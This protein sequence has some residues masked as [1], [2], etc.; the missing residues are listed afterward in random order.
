MFP[1]T[2][3]GNLP[4][5]NPNPVLENYSNN[6]NFGDE[7]KIDLIEKNFREIIEVLGPDMKNDSL[8]DSPYRVAK[9]FVKEI[10][11]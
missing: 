10:F 7:T 3:L 9:M 4:G 2:G 11:S 8:K 5:K 1:V 6:F